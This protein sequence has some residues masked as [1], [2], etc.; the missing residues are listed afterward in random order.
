MLFVALFSLIVAWDRPQWPKLE[1][2]GVPAL[3]AVRPAAQPAV[4][5][6]SRMVSVQAAAA[7]LPRFQKLDGRGATLPDSASEWDCVRDNEHKLVWEE[8]Q[9]NGAVRDVDFTYSWY[10]SHRDAGVRDGGQCYFIDCD[11][12]H[13]VEAVNREGLCGWQDWRLPTSEELM[14]LDTDREYYSPDIDQRYFL[15]TSPGYYWT[16][17][18]ANVGATLVWS[19][20]FLNG[21]PYVTE[22]RLAHHVRLVRGE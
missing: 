19:I 20:N 8:K 13:L 17:T 14:T 15:H 11:T 3:H 4:K 21:F 16:S 1:N 7:P 9:N 10:S 5:P 2:T 22:M 18:A 6:A 12:E